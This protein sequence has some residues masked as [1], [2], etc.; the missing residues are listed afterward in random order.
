MMDKVEA[1]LQQFK[2]W[3]GLTAANVDMLC[4]A[5]I[6]LVCGLVL[7]DRGSNILLSLI[8]GLIGAIPGGLFLKWADLFPS[9]HFVGAFCGALMV[10]GVKRIFSSDAS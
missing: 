9:C 8:M 10:L 4:Y 2:E 1:V 7:R 3:S 5:L 6:G